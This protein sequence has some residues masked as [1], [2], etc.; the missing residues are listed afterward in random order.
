MS[1]SPYLVKRE[2]GNIYLV[3]RNID[4][5]GELAAEAAMCNWNKTKPHSLPYG[6]VSNRIVRDGTLHLH[7]TL[8]A[9]KEISQL[10]K[11]YQ[12]E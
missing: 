5:V 12:G 9:R 11:N 7:M 6:Y 3:G 2:R 10:V 1:S 8:L 4:L